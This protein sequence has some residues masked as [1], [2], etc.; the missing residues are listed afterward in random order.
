MDPEQSGTAT[1][2][3]TVGAEE[4]MAEAAIASER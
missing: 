4:L 2:D 3:T 1:Q